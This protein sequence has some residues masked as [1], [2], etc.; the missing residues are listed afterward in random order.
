MN[1]HLGSC[2]PVRHDT[3]WTTFNSACSPVKSSNTVLKLF[4]S[5][6]T[7]SLGVTPEKW[8][9]MLHHVAYSYNL[10]RA[11]ASQLMIH[12][13]W[14]TWATYSSNQRLACMDLRFVKA[15]VVRSL[16][17]KVQETKGGRA[18]PSK[19]LGVELPLQV[20]K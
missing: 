11:T 7:S 19:M 10:R 12:S 4:M 20:S 8:V 16:S 2:V 17:W 14:K 1:H 9:Q 15:T 13:L 6:I 18:P 3:T 5:L